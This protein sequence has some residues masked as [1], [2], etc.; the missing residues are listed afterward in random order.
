[1]HDEKPIEATY[2]AQKQSDGKKSQYQGDSESDMNHQ[3]SLK[4]V[5]M[6]GIT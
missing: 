1:M 5:K 6:S 4:L 3:F 2:D